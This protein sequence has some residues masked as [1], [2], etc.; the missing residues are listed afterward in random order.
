MLLN[1]FIEQ[2]SERDTCIHCDSSLRET[3]VSRR[4]NCNNKTIRPKIKR[5]CVFQGY[6]AVPY[7]SP[8]ILKFLNDFVGISPF[9][10]TVFLLTP[11][12]NF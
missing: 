2:F 6:P 12:K 11:Y 5:N 3:H 4:Y 10:R 9:G 1:M 8:P 7:F